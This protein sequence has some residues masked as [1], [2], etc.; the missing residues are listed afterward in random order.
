V[1]RLWEGDYPAGTVLPRIKGSRLEADGHPSPSIFEVKNEWIY[2]LIF[3][4]AFMA[5]TGKNLNFML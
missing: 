2:T 1:S 4:Y 5:C 3:P